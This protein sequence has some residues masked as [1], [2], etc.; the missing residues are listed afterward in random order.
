VLRGHVL[1]ANVLDARK[2]FVRGYAH[3]I[4]QSFREADYSN[5]SRPQ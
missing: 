5:P 4:D 2:P 3:S 1:Q